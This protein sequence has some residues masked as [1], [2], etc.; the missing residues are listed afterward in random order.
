METKRFQHRHRV[1]YAE[2]TAGNHVYHARF[3]NILEEA[4]GEFFRSLGLSLLALQETGT[5]FPVTECKMRFKSFARYDDLLTIEVWLESL[6]RVRL[7]FGHRILNVAGRVLL[8]AE[9]VH[10]CTNL[11]EKPKRMPEELIKLIEPFVARPPSA[12]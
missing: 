1:T 6:Q 7:S 4:R 11:Q 10:V 5:V 2:C 9:T 8:E 12:Q 3:L